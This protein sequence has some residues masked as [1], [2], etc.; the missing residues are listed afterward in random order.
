MATTQYV[1]ARYVPRHMGEWDSNTQYGALDV[2]LYTDGNSYT[3]KCFP[4]KGTPPT[5]Y[6]YWSISAQFNQQLAD[7]DEKLKV[8]NLKAFGF[9]TIEDIVNVK[10]GDVGLCAG[11]SKAN[12]GGGFEFYVTDSPAYTNENIAP[13]SIE[14]DGVYINIIHNGTFNAKWF[15]CK[16][17]SVTDDTVAMQKAINAA[18]HLGAT[19]YLPEG[20]YVISSQLTIDKRMSMRGPT[21]NTQLFSD[22]SYSATLISNISGNSPMLCLSSGNPY[23]ED[24]ATAGPSV[25][26]ISAIRMISKDSIKSRV[27][28]YISGN[29]GIIKNLHISGFGI[30]VFIQGAYYNRF[31]NVDINNCYVSMVLD[32]AGPENTLSG[33]WF[34]YADNPPETFDE[35]QIQSI[36]PFDDNRLSNVVLYKSKLFAENTAFE[37]TNV[38]LNCKNDTVFRGYRINMERIKTYY[39]D[40][41]SGPENPNSVKLYGV[42]VWNPSGYDPKIKTG[43]RDTVYFEFDGVEQYD[44][45][46][47]EFESAYSYIAVRNAAKWLY[48]T[49]K[50]EGFTSSEVINRSHFTETGFELD[51]TIKDAVFNGSGA[52]VYPDVG[53]NVITNKTDMPIN[54]IK[55]DN[56]AD[57]L[58][59][60]VYNSITNKD[61]SFITGNY[62]FIHI[63]ATLECDAIK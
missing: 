31:E 30:G 26:S 44:A 11:Y 25:F 33:C 38:A 61:G 58:R 18:K 56:S 50:T 6:Q 42:N 60:T 14:K 55:D 4:P 51:V 27:A 9:N 34:Q 19:L 36:L 57:V 48:N 29:R 39:I 1:G 15:G 28:V 47:L 59:F 32:N 49:I 52:F 3:A 20:G 2:V 23:N 21:E 40:A 46:K 13:L 10:V 22:G 16:G 7:V 62:K 5:N 37:A 8:L 53:E 12:D 24:F 41:Q 54:A 17:D 43:Y 45:E 63:S 35:K